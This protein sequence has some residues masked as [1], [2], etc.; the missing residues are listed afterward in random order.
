MWH[1]ARLLNGMANAI[2]SLCAIIVLAACFVWF[3]RKPFF[4]LKVIQVQEAEGKPLRHVNALTIRGI[5]TPRI[6]GNFFTVDLDA[7]REAFRAVPWVRDVAVR[8]K[9]PNE[10]LVLVEEHKPLGT[11]GDDGKLLSVKGDVFTV[12]LAEAESEGF[13]LRFY[14]PEGSGKDVVT[15]YEEL[16]RD[17][18]TIGVTP[19]LLALSDRYAWRTTLDNGLTVRFGQEQEKNAMRG[20]MKRLL[21]VYPRLAAQLKNGMKSIDLRYPNGLALKAEGLA[22]VIAGQEKN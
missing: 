14:G 20:Q 15:R 11:W 5:A 19:V 13:L 1:D 7:V 4:S 18:A 21:A 9:W 2:F 10:L 3:A 17:F 12:N 16:Q 8:R 6:K 22:P